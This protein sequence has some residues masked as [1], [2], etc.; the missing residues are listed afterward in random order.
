VKEQGNP[1]GRPGSLVRWV[2]R[3][4]AATPVPARLAVVLVLDGNDEIDITTTE[5]LG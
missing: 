5:Q 2:S 3:R 4:V 1:P